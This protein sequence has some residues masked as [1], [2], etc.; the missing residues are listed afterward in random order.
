ME[1]ISHN[2]NAITVIEFNRILDELVNKEGYLLQIGDIKIF[3]QGIV[4]D[5]LG[6]KRQVFQIQRK[7]KE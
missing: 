3:N 7:V 4:E 6:G 5:T 2:I 1:K